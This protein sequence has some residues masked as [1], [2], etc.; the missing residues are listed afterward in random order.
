M[1]NSSDGFTNLEFR[2]NEFFLTK[3]CWF[4]TQLANW[5]KNCLW[6]I[7]SLASFS[8]AQSE[9]KFV[10]KFSWYKLV[11]RSDEFVRYDMVK[12]FRM[13]KSNK[14]QTFPKA[15]R[16]MALKISKSSNRTWALGLGG[17]EGL[18]DWR[19]PIGDAATICR[20]D[21]DQTLEPKTK[22]GIRH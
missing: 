8:T 6:I 17:L 3:I 9:K 21:V 4:S 5:E 16:P 15:P 18:L 14:K 11:K 22:A 12:Y 19:A 20:S 1:T 13:W 2:I 7:K 10:E